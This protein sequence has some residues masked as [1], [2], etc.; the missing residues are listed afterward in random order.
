MVLVLLSA[1]VERC[2]VS[3]MRYFS[4]YMPSLFYGCGGG[5]VY[6]EGG[7]LLQGDLPAGLVATEETPG[8]VAEQ[9]AHRVD[10][11]L[12]VQVRLCR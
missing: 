10:R 5:I 11:V 7:Q 12:G 4:T 1:S 8:E 9:P 3:R 2:F 6:E